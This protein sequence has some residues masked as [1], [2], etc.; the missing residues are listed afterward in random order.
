MLNSIGAG[1]FCWTGLESFRAPLLLQKIGPEALCRCGRLRAAVLP[2]RLEVIGSN[3]FAHSGLRELE[4]PA[5]VSEISCFAF[6]GCAALKEVRCAP[7][8]RLGVIGERAF[9]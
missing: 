3:C 6:W 4:V 5:R 8:S 2:A 7:G 9:Y 1:A